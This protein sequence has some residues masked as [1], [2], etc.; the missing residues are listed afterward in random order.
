MKNNR[1]TRWLVLYIL[2]VA[3]FGVMLGFA[4]RPA[5][6]ALGTVSAPVVVQEKRIA[7]KTVGTLAPAE[8]KEYQQAK[9][10]ETDPE[11]AVETAEHTPEASKGTY[12]GTFTVTHYCPYQCCNGKWAGMT[13]SG[14]TPTPWYTIAV[15]TRKI[16][17]GSK[18]YIE[19]YGDFVAQDRG[20]AI[21]G[22]RIDVLVGSHAE[23]LAL[24]VK[25]MEVYLI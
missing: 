6:K 19:G 10:D 22:N 9:A 11:N 20:G 13:A 14:A 2:L 1:R 5:A 25:K 24:G 23:A 15:D 3:A 16:P 7:P 12:L 4:S 21:K 17:M 8:V 18:V